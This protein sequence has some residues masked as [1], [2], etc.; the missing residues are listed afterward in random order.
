MFLKRFKEKSIRKYVNGILK[1]R[2]TNVSDRKIESVGIILSRDEYDQRDEFLLFFK[3]HSIRE[4]RIRFIT[5]IDDESNI[6]NQW[7]V[8]FSPKDF[9]WKGKLNNLDLQEFVEAKFDVLISYYR[10]DSL[11]LNAVTALSRANFKI[12]ISDKDIRLNDMII[13]VRT[14][15][16]DIF[17]KEFLKYSKTLNKI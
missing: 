3:D 4:N 6:P 7:D 17:M 9:G 12:G 8:Y 16:I 2:N 14:D 11:E 5:F 13:D 1:N 10:H 15:Q